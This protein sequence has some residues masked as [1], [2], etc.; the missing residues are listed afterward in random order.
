MINERVQGCIADTLT[1]VLGN[2]TSL[3]SVARTYCGILPPYVDT[4]L[5]LNANGTHL[6]LHTYKEMQNE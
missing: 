3:D 6:L 1:V 5:T 4:T 2:R